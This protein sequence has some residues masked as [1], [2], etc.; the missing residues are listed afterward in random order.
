M[1]HRSW[2]RRLA[3]PLCLAAAV[4]A[5]AAGGNKEGLIRLPDHYEFDA[6]LSASF[7]A[8]AVGQYPIAV[9]FDFPAGAYP[10]MGTWQLDVVSPQGKVVQR[11]LGETP[12]ADGRGNYRFNWNGR[13]SKGGVLKAGFY[14]LRL[15]AVP[16]VMLDEE[17]NLSRA[18]RA[19]RSFALGRNELVEQRYDIRIGNV[20][21][22]NMPSFSGLPHGAKARNKSV[23]GIKSVGASTLPY[24]IYYGN[25]HSQTN[26]SDGGTPVASCGGAETPQAGSFGPADAFAMMDN[27]AGGDFLLASEHNHMYD[28]STGTNTAASPATANN[29]FA[30]GLTAAANYRNAHP[31]FLALYGNEWGVI[32]NGGHLNIINP[33]AL[34]SWEYNASNQLIGSV[35]TIKSDYA[36][37]Y[38][39]M[40]QRGWIGQFNHPSSSQFAIGGTGMKYDANGAEVM[41]LAEVLNSSAFSTN[42]TET[43]TGRSTYTSAWNVLLER[44]YKVAPTT[45]QDNHCAN[46]GLS[47]RNRTG[48]LLPNGVALNVA[49]FVDA[50]KAR[51]VFAS[52]DKNAQLV[53]TANGQ[54]MGQTISNNG[55]LTLTANYASTVGGTA[56]RVQ[57]FEGVPGRNGTVTQLFEGAGSTSITPTAG[58]HFY[59]AAVT[60]ADG[61]RLWSA[62][63]WVNQGAG[64]GD[65]TAP[66]VSASETGTSGNITLAATA[67]DNV[68]VTNVEFY[69]DGVLKGSDASS[70]YSLVLDST[71]LTNGSHN[72]T[73]KASDA[74]GNS[75][76]STTAAFSVNNVT[77]DTTAPTVSASESGTSGTIT[78]SA[79]ASDNVGVTNVEFYIDGVLKGADASSPYS[80]TV[81]STTLSNASHS[82]TAKAFDAAGNSKIS[83]AVSF[84][85]SNTTSTQFN[86]TESN[87]SVAT[88]NAVARSFKTIVGTMGNT[89][90]KDYF[91]V[92]LAAGETIK[93]DMVGPSTTD[94]D[95][96]LVNASD[97][98]LKSSAGNTSTET[99]TYTNGASAATVYAKVISY[100]GSSTTS[101]YTLTLT[102]TTGTTTTE[103]IGNGG[104]ESGNTVWTASSGVIDNGTGQAARTGSWK[105]WMNGYGSVHTDTMVQT[106]SIP[107]AAS[108]ATLSF[109]LK[110]VSS[111]TTTTSAYDTLKVQVRNSGGTVLST[112]KT[113][114]NLDKGTTYVQRTF[115][116]SAYKGQTVQIYFEGVEGSTV[117]TAFLIDDV[118]L[119]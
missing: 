1:S 118:S 102:Y 75:T 44:G 36:N 61:D 20:A 4:S 22:P 25:M 99:L 74:A 38:A 7:Q 77:A 82:L 84:T 57:F 30:S 59:Y 9:S 32:S 56:A 114:S 18:E 85:V 111:E 58:A 50:L 6:Q 98:A 94:Y 70:P 47:F 28:G 101:P 8:N 13:D 72:L 45:D 5:S 3:L 43:E 27:Q 40:K 64:S 108:T 31:D 93:I 92:A 119:K 89:T 48:V 71:T 26:H 41:V 90:D 97:V 87:G 106:V 63:I 54:V 62:P 49:N 23:V 15:R 109:W 100:S 51:R 24:T 80:L 113:Y 34:S 88:A 83:T 104:F 42:T 79:T 112:L 103:L 76:T 2:P 86:E 39:V 29:L 110:V 33:D 66:T 96:A 95:L 14:T 115:D 11:W 12:L 19:K 69:V 10:T 35:A 78:L 21:S 65:T 73:A 17:K 53:L 117:S 67:S 107:A 52:E 105:A 91:A 116:L 68:G 81:D 60:E 55:S 37:L 16:S 46:W